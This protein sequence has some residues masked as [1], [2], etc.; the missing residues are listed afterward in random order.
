LS[1]GSAGYPDV[2]FRLAYTAPIDSIVDVLA[3]AF[4]E[5]KYLPVRSGR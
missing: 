3:S 1:V 5:P 4:K 2:G